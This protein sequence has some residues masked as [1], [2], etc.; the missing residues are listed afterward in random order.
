MVLMRA[1]ARQVADKRR[2][3]RGERPFAG[4]DHVTDSR[5]H[6]FFAVPCSVFKVPPLDQAQQ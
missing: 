4:G 3:Q 1:P 6:R 2:A 5:P